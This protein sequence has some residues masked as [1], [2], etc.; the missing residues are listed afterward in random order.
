MELFAV[1]NLL[2]Q[3][4]SVARDNQRS[5]TRPV[6]ISG[7]RLLGHTPPSVGRRHRAVG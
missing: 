5:V 7:P 1:I 4:G 6:S 3:R 2:L